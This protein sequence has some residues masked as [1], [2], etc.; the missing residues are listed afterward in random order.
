VTHS[1]FLRHLSVHGGHGEVVLSH[2]V[3]QPVHF[4]LGVAEDHRLGDGERVVQVAEGVE[5]PLFLLHS[6]KELLDT[7]V[8]IRQTLLGHC[9]TYEK[10]SLVTS[11][12]SSSLFT[13]ILTG[14]FMNFMVMSNTS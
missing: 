7:L 4:L 11:R 14:S 9:G 3:G 13:R 12:V 10:R 1:V 5:L 8:V 2:L 6:H